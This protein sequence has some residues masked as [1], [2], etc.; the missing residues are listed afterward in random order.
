MPLFEAKD[1]V[2]V[3]PDLYGDLERSM[4]KNFN[5]LQVCDV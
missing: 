5:L 1:S 3:A 2:S 4:G